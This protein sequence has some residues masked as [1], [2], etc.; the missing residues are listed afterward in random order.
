ME[1]GKAAVTGEL[2]VTPPRSDANQWS[3]RGMGDGMPAHGDPT[4]PR[5]APSGG[6]RDRRLEARE[7]RTG[8]LGV[9]DRPVRPRTPG[10]AGRGKGP[11]FKTD[12]RRGMRA[13]RLAMSLP[14]P[15]KVQ[16][17]Q[18]A[19]HAKAKGTAPPTASTRCTTRCTGRT[20]WKGPTS[21][22]VPTTARGVDH[23]TF[24][25]IEAYGL[26]RWLD[27]LAT[28]LEAKTYRPQ[29]V[30]HVC[31][32]KPDGKQR[33]LGIGSIR[34]RVAQMAVVLVLEPIFEADLEPEQYAYR[35]NRSAVGCR[36]ARPRAGQHGAYGSRRCRFIE[37]LRRN[38]PRRT[39]QVALP[40]DQRSAPAGADQEMAGG[41]GRGDRQAGSASPDNA[42]QGRGRGAPRKESTSSPPTGDLLYASVSSTAENCWDTRRRLNATIVNYAD[43]SHDLLSSGTRRRGD[44]HDAAPSMGSQVTVNDVQDAAVSDSRGDVH[45][46]GYTIGQYYSPHTGRTYIGPPVGDEDRRALSGRIR[47]ARPPLTGAGSRGPVSARSTVMLG[48]GQLLLPRPRD[49]GVPCPRP[50]RLSSAASVALRER[51]DDPGDI[52]GSPIVPARRV[53]ADPPA[54]R[55]KTFRGRKHESLSESRMRENRPSGSMSGEWKRGTVEL[56]RH[57]QTKGPATDRPSLNY[58]EYSSTLR[59]GSRLTEISKLSHV[60]VKNLP[61]GGSLEAAG[62]AY[63]QSGG[64]SVCEDHYPILRTD[65][66]DV[67]VPTRGDQAEKQGRV[68]ELAPQIPKVQSSTGLTPVSARPLKTRDS[69]MQWWHL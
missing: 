54:H 41:A 20:C 65:S 42:Q 11:E 6:G 44:D 47:E 30:R 14:P 48:Y 17:L 50:A 13:G 58:R 12:V 64:L 59:R 4:Q 38:P 33:P 31:I 60:Y 23:Q 5:E 40:P 21:A 24:E 1:T 16:K 28:E 61:V 8:P 53:G 36:Q 39:P 43:D 66:P 62:E 15:P 52:H 51:G 25:D 26:E 69:R 56:L 49:P 55:T 29:P 35:A 45:V 9:A 57:R 27:E 10:N 63:G 19:L 34:D 46:S 32:P 2:G 67:Q 3:H 7:G 18:E 68:S 22:V 37:L